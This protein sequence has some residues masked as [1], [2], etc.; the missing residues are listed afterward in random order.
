M[1]HK[2]RL[3]KTKLYNDIFAIKDEFKFISN[4]QIGRMIGL[5]GQRVGWIIN[6]YKPDNVK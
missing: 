6:N 3:S 5:S 1:E 4:A 2:P